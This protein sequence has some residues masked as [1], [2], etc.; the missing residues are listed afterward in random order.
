MINSYLKENLFLTSVI[1]YIICSS[2]LKAYTGLDIGIPCIWKSL[3]HIEC[4]GCGLTTAFVGVLKLNFTL[5]IKS[6]WLI[7][8]IIPFG[9]YYIIDDMIRYKKRF[10]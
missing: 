2:L 4:I 5:A 9:T 8:I 3:F 10:R 1:L 6:N 7:F